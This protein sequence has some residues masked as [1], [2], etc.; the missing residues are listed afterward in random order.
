MQINTINEDFMMYVTTGLTWVVNKFNS[1]GAD[2]DPL[3]ILEIFAIIFTTVCI[4]LA[5]R[6]NIHTWWTGFVGCVLFGI[7][8]FNVNLYANA[9]LQVF[10]MYTAVI[11]WMQWKNKKD[12]SYLPITNI[13]KDQFFKY[14]G[15]GFIV[16]ALYCFFFINFTNAYAPIPDTATAVLSVVSQYML[17]H[18]KLQAWVGWFIVNLISVP[19]FFSDGLELMGILYLFY[20]FH[21]VYAFYNWYTIK[22]EQ[23]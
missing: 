15:I 3:L 6:N 18:K 22:K 5:G 4:F 20:L 2:P 17:I 12:E 9:I 19:L 8:F 14:G 13:T 1:I 23:K 21:S 7:L 10:F 16:G 11:G